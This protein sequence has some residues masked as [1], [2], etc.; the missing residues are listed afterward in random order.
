M[1]GITGIYH[2][3]SDRPVDPA[4]LMAMT[5]LLA[6]RGPDDS[7]VY[8]AGNLG[9]GHRRL[10]IVDLSA[11]GRNPMPNEDETLWVTYNGEIYNVR[12]RRPEFEARGHRFRSRTDTEML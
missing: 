5:D 4:R 8:V 2:Y 10:A 6:H 7:G 1:C 12:E 3:G 11:A 9:L